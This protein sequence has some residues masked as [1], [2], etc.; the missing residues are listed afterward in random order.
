VD[1]R[2]TKSQGPLEYLGSATLNNMLRIH[3]AFT[4][5]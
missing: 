4:A 5:T 2:G 1:N 3:D